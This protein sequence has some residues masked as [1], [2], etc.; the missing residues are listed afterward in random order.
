M[1]PEEFK[2]P[3][4]VSHNIPNLAGNSAFCNS[5]NSDFLALMSILGSFTEHV[6]HVV[7]YMYRSH[8]YSSFAVLFIYSY[9][10]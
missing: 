8:Y 3:K 9:H 4:L 1:L 10:L 5:E 7:I 6:S 2:L